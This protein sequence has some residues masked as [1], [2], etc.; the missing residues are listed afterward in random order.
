MRTKEVALAQFTSAARQARLYVVILVCLVVGY[1][2]LVPLGYLLYT[3][4]FD[5]GSFSLAP[6]RTA[7]AVTG[8][9]ELA[10]NTTVFGVGSTLL[11]VGFGTFLAYCTERTNIPAKKTIFAVALVPLIIP[12]ILYAI[13][14]VILASPRIGVLNF[15]LAPF[16]LNIDIFTM[17]GMIWVQGLDNVPLAF[18]L[19]VAAFRSM[20][21][22]LEESAQAC[23]ASLWSVVRKITL[24]LA[25]PALLAATLI[26]FV[27]NIESFE[28]PAVLGIPG[29]IWVLTSQIWRV[30]D[31]WPPGYAEAGAY[32]VTLLAVTVFGIFLY[33]RALGRG[34]KYQTVTGKGYKAGVVDLGRAR[35]PLFAIAMAYTVV[36]I[37]IPVA[38]L[39]YTS[40]T[41]FW[42]SV[43][44]EALSTLT[45]SNYSFVFENDRVARAAFNSLILSGGAATMVMLLMAVSAWLVIRSKAPGR[46]ILDNLSFVPLVIPGIVM[47]VALLIVYLRIPVHIYGTMWILFIAYSTKGMPYGMRYA[48]ASIYQLGV[49]LEES[50][51]VSGAS[52]LQT[53]RRVVLPL[54]APGLF[55]GWLYILMSSMRELSASLLLYSP[56]REVMAVLIW[57]LREEAR[58]P[59]LAALGIVMIILLLIIVTIAIQ[60]AKKTGMRVTSEV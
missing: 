34:K 4:L 31:Q 30:L 53:F 40:L 18:L 7:Y 59:A 16:G 48:S 54:L 42:G 12:G 10:R 51:Y 35:M 56:G 27:R 55:A 38:A 44:R 29:N 13:S 11:S 49:E 5:G 15:A 50:A 47:G 1:L 28:T 25:L 26:M 17:P 57:Q 39:L 58:M 2:A 23:G 32:S 3:T 8:F 46:T 41:P 21:P 24:P 19:M 20:D 52:W 33:Y 43:S 60:V 6:F 9:W 45:L 36:S 22:T 37:V 14:W